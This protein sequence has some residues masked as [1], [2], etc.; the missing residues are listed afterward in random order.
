MRIRTGVL[1]AGM[2]FV[3]LVCSE[4]LTRADVEKAPSI[5]NTVVEA[6]GGDKGV[7]GLNSTVI[8]HKSIVLAVDQS[9]KAVGSKSVQRHRCG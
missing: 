6:H 4:N 1:L 9:R 8:E 2:M 5:I 7:S 3:S